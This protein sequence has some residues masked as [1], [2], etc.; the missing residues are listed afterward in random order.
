MEKYP[1]NQEI[2]S[3]YIDF[4]ISIDILNAK[5]IIK[6]LLDKD[7]NNLFLWNCFALIEYKLLNIQQSKKIYNIALSKLNY[8]I[9]YYN[10]AF[11]EFQDQ[12]F[13]F[14]IFILIN[15]V[16]NNNLNSQEI[17]ISKII[18]IKARN[19]FQQK[20]KLLFEEENINSDNN[21]S[22]FC[23]F[24]KSFCL[25]EY[26]TIGIQNSNL[27]YQ[28][29]LL[30]LKNKNKN[31]IF[32][33]IIEDIYV[34]YCNLNY[35]HFKKE[36]ETSSSIIRNI[37][38]SAMD[39]FPNNILFLNLF[40]ELE[41]ESK[42]TNRIRDYFDNICEN[43]NT[44]IILY[45]FSIYSET[46]RNFSTNRIRVLFEKIIENNLL[47]SN[48]ILWKYFIYFELSK[49][50]LNSL[51]GIIYRSLQK[52]PFSKSIILFIL[53]HLSHILTKNELNNILNIMIEKQI[54][55][56]KLPNL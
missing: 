42:I 32:D 21:Y 53:Q 49:G 29:S 36:K 56:R 18:I 54:R 12:N 22:E 27:I 3:R 48:V 33:K 34:S 13:N 10:Y 20:L 37:I 28:N 11:I 43:K 23:Y 30:F 19:I 6:L 14:S 50:F 41:M 52:I 7:R 51:K 55:I 1:K 8:F 9:L 17:N 46:K 47:N 45:L 4:E 35:F 24:I 39:L 16:L 40:L 31:K 38:Y 15:S 26:L 5:S 2:I 44:S 25:F